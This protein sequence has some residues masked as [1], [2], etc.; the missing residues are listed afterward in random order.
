MAREGSVDWVDDTHAGP[1][2]SMGRSPVRA[3]PVTAGARLTFHHHYTAMARRENG[4]RIQ[5]LIAAALTMGACFHATAQDPPAAPEVTEAADAAEPRLNL[6]YDELFGSLPELSIKDEISV[7]LID[8]GEL[9]R[10]VEAA[11]AQE[12]MRLTLAECIEIAL[13][14]NPDIAIASYDPLIS[15]ADVLA[16]KG[17]FDPRLQATG[18]YIKATSSLSQ[19]NVAFGGVS[20]VDSWQTQ[21]NVGSV[22]YTHLTLPTN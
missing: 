12:E 1:Y 5:I 18:T 7:D 14:G 3:K 4:M 13:A 10:A 20:A 22:S 15:E 19:Q 8:L 17:E 9:R 21:T 16:S 11:D 2:G 6:S